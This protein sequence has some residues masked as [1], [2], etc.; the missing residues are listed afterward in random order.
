MLRDRGDTYRVLLPECFPGCP[1]TPCPA[2]CSGYG[3]PFVLALDSRNCCS[4]RA[5]F[6]L[7][8]RSWPAAVIVR[9]RFDLLDVFDFPE[10]DDAVEL[11]T[12]GAKEFAESL[13][14]S[15]PNLLKMLGKLSVRPRE[16][17]VEFVRLSDTGEELADLEPSSCRREVRRWSRSSLTR[18]S[19]VTLSFCSCSCLAL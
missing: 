2:S 11:A 8:S 18:S 14:F 13:R 3:L 10:S 16:S 15:G 17:F 4:S 7:A 6:P 19:F 1:P 5:S 12:E 9:Q